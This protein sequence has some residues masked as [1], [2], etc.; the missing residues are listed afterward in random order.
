LLSGAALL[1]KKRWRANASARS[2]VKVYVCGK[3]MNWPKIREAFEEIAASTHEATALEFPVMI[4]ELE[5]L[6][7][8]MQLRMLNGS[9]PVPIQNALGPET[10]QYLNVEEVARRFHVTPR[11]LY[12]HKRKM[13]HSQPS[14]KL[15][16]FPEEAITKWF[17][18]RRRT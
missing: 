14:R 18:S 12:R 9:P 5:R 17:A 7:L 1:P 11:W 13:P 15:L 16:L 10:G 4:G 8:L 2:Q 3:M 6:K